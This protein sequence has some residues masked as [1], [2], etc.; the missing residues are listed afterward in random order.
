YKYLPLTIRTA[1]RQ[2]AYRARRCSSIRLVFITMTCAWSKMWDH[3]CDTGSVLF[4][5][6]EIDS[7][8]AFLEVKTR[9][10]DL[11][12]NSFREGRLLASASNRSSLSFCLPDPDGQWIEVLGPDQV[13]M[14]A[15]GE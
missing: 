13:E 8:D 6:V 10:Q 14:A 1:L 11:A 3:E 15:D 12:R 4:F 7:K 2:C 9:A 5:S